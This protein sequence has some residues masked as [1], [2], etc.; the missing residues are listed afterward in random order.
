MRT[1][2]LSSS[3]RHARLCVQRQASCYSQRFSCLRNFQRLKSP[4][5]LTKNPRFSPVVIHRH[6]YSTSE[7]PSVLQDPVRPS[8]CYHLMNAPNP[9]SPDLPAYAV[10]MLDTPPKNPRSPAIMGWLLAASTESNQEAGI[11]D[12]LENDEFLNVIHDLLRSVIQQNSDERLASEAIQ[13]GFGWM[14][15]NDDRNLP[16][17]GR[18]SRPDDIIAS[19][20][21]EDG[22]MLPETYSPMPTY[23]VCT[24]DGLTT[25]SPELEEKL[26]F[27][28]RQLGH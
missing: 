15:I 19:V 14:H 4:V 17:V 28:L 3:L 7:L 26:I 18:I 23:R 2:L 16:E 11:Q 24:T 12:F 20:R 5:Q 8:I 1:S 13:L 22:K 6:G 25:L 9:L 27:K 10:S 21:V